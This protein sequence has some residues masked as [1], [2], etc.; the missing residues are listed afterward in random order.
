MFA[1]CVIDCTRVTNPAGSPA[2]LCITR[3]GPS[4]ISDNVGSVT[5]AELAALFSKTA[6]LNHWHVSSW[7]LLGAWIWYSECL[8]SGNLRSFTSAER[9]NCGN[10][11]PLVTVN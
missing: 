2:V 11:Q 8:I 6:H 7:E 4:G 1:C 3:I 5:Y 9:V 10:W